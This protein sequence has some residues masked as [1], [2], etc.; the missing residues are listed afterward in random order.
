[1]IE[2]R[3]FYLL[4]PEISMAGIAVLV[5]LADLFIER[6]N[7]L[8][9]LATLLLG[10]PLGFT[11][12]LWGEQDTAFNGF[13]IVDNY[14]VFF[15]LLFIGVAG[16]A[17]MASQSAASR[18]PRFQ[19]EYYALVLFATSGLMLLSGTGELL[20]IYVS[21]ELSTLSAIALVTFF[22]DQR[23]TEAGAK[24]LV[25][26]G[27]SSGLM[28]YGMAFIF[29]FTGETELGEIARAVGSV[30][31]LDQPGLLVGVVL[32]VAGFGF[33]ISAFPFHMWV[34]DV[35]QGAPTPITAFLSVASKAAGFA[36]LL[37]VFYAAF[38][39]LVLDWSM[40]FAV[41]AVITMTVGNLTAMFQQDI[42]RLLA[43]SAVAHAGYILIGVAAVAARAPGS[44]AL[45][46]QGVLFYLGGYAFTNLAA[47]FVV[48]AVDHRLRSNQIDDYAGLGKRAPLLAALLAIALISLTGLPPT[49]GFWG[50]LYVFNAAV[51][52][53]LVW[54]A[55]AGGINST[56]SAYY[57]LRVVKTM[58]MSPAKSEEPITAAPSM[59]VPLLLTTAG[60]L[61]FG[62]APGFLLD[63]AVN[64]VK[65]FPV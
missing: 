64:A 41:L 47:F 14:A 57:Y 33:K 53:D 12:V 38:P 19:G 46:P 2:A 27:V 9:P 8:A 20:T 4:S 21:L 63:F 44:E 62:F 28:I 30:G 56:I 60:V 58:F 55:V 6:K 49:V 24:Y 45:G 54:L 31:L 34:P 52:A 36:L 1:M 42:K 48:I 3:D 13:F 29:G 32:L 65:A 35:Y 59:A 51:N 39:G 7:L 22:K 16:M 40:L 15:K 18:F 5:I 17:A 26:S 50:K 23:S 10:I 25:L 11:I 61:F 37:R 43:Y